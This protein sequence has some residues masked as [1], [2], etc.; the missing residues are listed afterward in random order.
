MRIDEDPSTWT[1]LAGWC[2]LGSVV[3]IVVLFAVAADAPL[4]TDPPGEIRDWIDTRST[5]N[6]TLAW[7][8]GVTDVLF[9][10]PFV[11]GASAFLGRA[12][13]GDRF[14]AQLSLIG[15][16]LTIPILWIGNGFTNGA[17][18][19]GGVDDLS[20]P[21]LITLIRASEY[22][23]AFGLNLAVALWI[24]AAGVTIV[25]NTAVA[26]WLGWIAIT[27]AVASLVGGLWIVDGD[28]ES[29]LVL[30]GLIGLIAVAVWMAGVALTMIRQDPSSATEIVARTQGRSSTDT[31]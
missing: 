12:A 19:V 22:L 21:T 25:R 23:M 7:F 15:G 14:L 26:S 10:V 27:G 2:G 17:L 3:A 5:M 28:P 30:G 16:L 18:L 11:V 13:P 24:G 8:E 20:D 31:R 9:F 1:R 4:S 29:P 6:L